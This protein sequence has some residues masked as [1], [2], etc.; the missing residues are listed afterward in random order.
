MGL[1]VKRVVV[2]LVVKGRV[3]LV[4]R[5]VVRSVN[6]EMVVVMGS[7]AQMMK[8]E[9]GMAEEV[10]EREAMVEETVELEEVENSLTHGWRS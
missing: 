9:Q 6:V 2:P 10:V 8:E 5:G 4:T 3:E 1:A 7:M